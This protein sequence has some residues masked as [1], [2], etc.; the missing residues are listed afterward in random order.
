MKK[1]LGFVI[2]SKNVY[3]SLYFWKKDL[4]L[5]CFF[6]GNENFFSQLKLSIPYKNQA[7]LPWSDCDG[8]EITYS[9]LKQQIYKNDLL[10]FG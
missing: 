5:P 3:A 10:K 6:L 4:L 2:W 1:N 9:S 7:I 8:N